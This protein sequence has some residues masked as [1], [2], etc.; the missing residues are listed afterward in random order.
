MKKLKLTVRIFLLGILLFFLIYL[1]IPSPEIPPLPNSLKSTEE[2]D[3]VQVP[4][5]AAYYSDTR[6]EEAV[7]FYQKSFALPFFD[8]PFLNYRLNHPPEYARE[9]VRDQISTSYFEEIVHPFRESLYINGFEPY[10]LLKDKPDLLKGNVM[11]IDEK[12]YFS[13]V[14]IRYLPSPLWERILVFG[15]GVILSFGLFMFWRRIV[16]A[17]WRL[18]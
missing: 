8:L 3:T 15:F 10:I 13:K 6:R 18:E 9:V 16:N 11:I 14:T 2:G 1:L 5:V 7:T 4:G 17:G 12:E